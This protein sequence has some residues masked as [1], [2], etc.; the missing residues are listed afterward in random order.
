MVSPHLEHCPFCGGYDCFSI[1]EKFFKCFQCDAKGDVFNF[2][3]KFEGLT[4]KEALERAAS[5]RRH[6]LLSP[7]HGRGAGS[8]SVG[9]PPS[10]KERIFAA[11]AGPPRS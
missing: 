9:E 3:E 2:L 5:N 10:V 11:A 6:P 1:E 4:Q 8:G 7:S